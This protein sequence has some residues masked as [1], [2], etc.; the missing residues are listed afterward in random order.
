MRC[1]AKTKTGQPCRAP[2]GASG[3]CVSHNPD[4]AE[5]RAKW[6]RR[7]G[8]ASAWARLL[9]SAEFSDK[10]ARALAAGVARSVHA[11]TMGVDVANTIVRLLSVDDKLRRTGAMERDIAELKD[12]VRAARERKGTP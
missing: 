8:K 6:R 2:A 3:Y 7:G 9:R 1:H 11:G 5:E 12:Y 4:I 10:T